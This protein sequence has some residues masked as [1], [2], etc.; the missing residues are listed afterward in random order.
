MD[1]S[2]HTSL[3]NWVEDYDLR[4]ASKLY[5]SLFASSYF[6]G[7]VFGTPLLAHMGDKYGR[8]YM[9]KRVIGASMVIMA[10][11]L[12]IGRSNLWISYTL[13]FCNGFVSNVRASLSFLYGQEII[14]RRDSSLFG[15]L[16]NIVDAMTM[17]LFTLYFRYITKHWIYS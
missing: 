15:S 9:L 10:L 14:H 11:M 8:L 7:Q 5:I 1:W 16:Y 3:H 4:C 17:I 2:S 13:I 6:F 12:I